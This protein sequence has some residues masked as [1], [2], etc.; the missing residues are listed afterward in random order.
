MMAEIYMVH[1]HPN[2]LVAMNP[3]TN[4]AAN[5]PMNTAMQKIDMTTPRCAALNRSAKTAGTRETGLAAKRPPKN[6]PSMMVWMSFPVAAAMV[7]IPHPNRP[8]DNGQRRP[9]SSDAGA[10]MVGPAANP[11]T[12]RVTPRV[13]TSRPTWNSLLT[14]ETAAEKT[15]LVKA[16]AKVE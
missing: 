1:L 10:Q 5:G 2:G 3:P 6:R 15:A 13:L 14:A 8:M 16:V 9:M 7:K 4:G 11:N 12:Y